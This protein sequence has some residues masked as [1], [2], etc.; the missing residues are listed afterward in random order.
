MGKQ[1]INR[2]QT[3]KMKGLRK[4][5]AEKKQMLMKRKKERQAARQSQNAAA[6]Q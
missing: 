1:D 3:R 4:T 5:P 2:L 6:E